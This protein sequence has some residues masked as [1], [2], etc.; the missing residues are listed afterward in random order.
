MIRFRSKNDYF[1]QENVHSCSFLKLLKFFHFLQAS[2]VISYKFFHLYSNAKNNFTSR[3][4]LEKS[5]F[6]VEKKR[7]KNYVN[8]KNVECRRWY[9]KTA[10]ETWASCQGSF[11]FPRLLKILFPHQTSFIKRWKIPERIRRM[12]FHVQSKNFKILQFL[13]AF[14]ES[15]FASKFMNIQNILFTISFVAFVPFVFE[16]S[17]CTDESATDKVLQELRA[18]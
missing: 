14:H 18:E 10:E 16:Y 13:L 2:F 6:V 1:H 9:E 8:A 7:W 11:T 12:I 5:H 15:V 17:Y 3:L 4:A